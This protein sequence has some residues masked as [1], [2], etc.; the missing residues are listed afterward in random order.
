MIGPD[1]IHD[2][3]CPTMGVA[4]AQIAWLGDV[5]WVFEPAPLV[6]LVAQLRLA[7]SHFSCLTLP[8]KDLSYAAIQRLSKEKSCCSWARGLPRPRW[9]SGVN[10]LWAALYNPS[11]HWE[12]LLVHK[13]L[14]YC[15]DHFLVGWPPTSLQMF[16]QNCGRVI[17]RLKKK[18]PVSAFLHTRRPQPHILPRHNS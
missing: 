16:A 4:L 8:S 12:G 11:V 14:K 6:T 1:E 2:C 10:I 15:S 9:L 5:G 18:S 7:S 13:Y 17:I 3:S